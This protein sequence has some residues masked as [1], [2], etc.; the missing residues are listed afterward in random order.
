MT[1]LVP[2][3]IWTVYRSIWSENEVRI[4]RSRTDAPFTCTSVGTCIVD[5]KWLSCCRFFT[6]IDPEL[7]TDSLENWGKIYD[8][9]TYLF[10]A[11]SLFSFF[12]E[13]I[14]FL[15]QRMLW[16]NYIC[17]KH[18]D[19]ECSFHCGIT[20]GGHSDFIMQLQFQLYR[21]FS[22]I[23]YVWWEL[24]FHCPFSAAVSWVPDQTLTWLFIQS[25]S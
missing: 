17:T 21:I 11:W 4:H 16:R 12:F 2:K 20:G 5:P 18:K 15:L 7:L 3:I 24:Q 25:H 6:W 1:K 9:S 8:V 22:W 19:L 14:Y 23:I 10:C 13:M